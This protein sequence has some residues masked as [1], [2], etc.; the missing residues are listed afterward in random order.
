LQAAEIATEEFAGRAREVA[1]RRFAVLL[2]A[3]AMLV[4]ACSGAASPSPSTAQP[5]IAASSAPASAQP[6]TVASSASASAPTSVAATPV[7]VSPSPGGPVFLTTGTASIKVSV[8]SKKE[9]FTVPLDPT[10]NLV[11][12]DGTVSAEWTNRGSGN[13]SD[14]GLL[15]NIPRGES[16]TYKDTFSVVSFYAK[17]LQSNYERMS[18]AVVVNPTPTGGVSGTIDCKGR[19]RGLLDPV[20]AKGTFAAEP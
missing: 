10:I 14:E 1:V 8:G 4:S 7:P 3:M 20:T 2:L 16:K 17:I 9:S 5:S 13:S 12:P 6:S 11:R 19:L 18:C 15:V